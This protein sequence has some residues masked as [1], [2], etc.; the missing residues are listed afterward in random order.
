MEMTAHMILFW[1]R[2]LKTSVFTYP[3]QKKNVVKTLCVDNSQ[4]RIKKM[5]FQRVF[6]RRRFSAVGALN[7]T[8]NHKNNIFLD[9]DWFKKLL[10]STNSVAKLL[11]ESLLSGQF[12]SHSNV[13]FKS[14]NHI[15]GFNQHRNSVKTLN[16]NFHTLIFFFYRK[17]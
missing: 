15:L 8:I 3:Y 7:G 1:R 16:A 14:T 12:K 2:F 13:Q 10:F 6:I 5:T 9:C 17:L 11:S 4:K